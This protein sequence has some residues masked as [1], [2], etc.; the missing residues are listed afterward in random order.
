MP[1]LHNLYHAQ[2]IKAQTTLANGHQAQIAWTAYCY[3]DTTVFLELRLI[4]ND[5]FLNKRKNIAARKLIKEHQPIVDEISEFL[6]VRLEESLLA[7]IRSCVV[8]NRNFDTYT[9]EEFCIS[10]PLALALLIAFA[11]KKQ[12]REDKAHALVLFELYCGSTLSPGVWD[13]R[14]V[15]NHFD[16][17]GLA[18]GCPKQHGAR[19]CLQLEHAAEIFKEPGNI[20]N[21]LSTTLLEIYSWAAYC[22]ASKLVFRALILDLAA[23]SENKLNDL[24]LSTTPTIAGPQ[25][26]QAN[27]RGKRIDEDFKK[28][29]TIQLPLASKCHGG[30]QYLRATGLCDERRARDWEA[31]HVLRYNTA[32]ILGLK[33]L[34]PFHTAQDAARNGKPAEDTTLFLAFET[35]TNLGGWLLL[36]VAGGS[37]ALRPKDSPIIHKVFRF[38]FR[39]CSSVKLQTKFA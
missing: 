10:V 18:C 17:H 19:W 26:A 38:V 13:E 20:W 9:R 32:M 27:G 21:K 39:W 14:R 22:T 24:Q 6:D 31:Q 25:S 37:A 23:A 3:K 15:F 2:Y 34:G 7:S 29:V 5:F 8:G 16:V 33:I 36:Q 30:S 12:S 28:M 4:F 35:A 1:S 11:R